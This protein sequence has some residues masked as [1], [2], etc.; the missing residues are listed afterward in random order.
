MCQRVELVLDKARK[1]IRPNLYG[2]AWHANATALGSFLVLD[3]WQVTPMR[4][5]SG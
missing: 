4:L 1:C 5:Q 3:R 2:F